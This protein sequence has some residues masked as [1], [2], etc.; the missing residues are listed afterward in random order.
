[1]ALVILTACMVYPGV[2]MLFQGLYPFCGTGEWF[3]LVSNPGPWLTLANNLGISPVIPSLLKAG[4]GAALVA[5]VL[6]LW[7]GDGKAYPVALAG[8]VGA[9]LY[10]WGPMVMG[11]IAIATLLLLRENAEEVPA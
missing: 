8:A 2:T 6:G 3:T 7:A 11:A 10:P 5:G 4:V 1:V 9:L